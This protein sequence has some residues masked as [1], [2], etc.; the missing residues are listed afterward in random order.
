[1]CW[2]RDMTEYYSLR[3]LTPNLPPTM[4]AG[5]ALTNVTEAAVRDTNTTRK[6]DMF[7][8]PE[9]AQLWVGARG[10]LTVDVLQVVI[11]N[12]EIRTCEII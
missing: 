9:R 8:R 5:E 12:P 11:S 1:M 10:V 4:A 3:S 6:I 2:A 7:F